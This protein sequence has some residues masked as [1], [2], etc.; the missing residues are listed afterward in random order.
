[1]RIKSYNKKFSLSKANLLRNKKF[2]KLNFNNKRRLYNRIIKKYKSNVKLFK[3]NK[4]VQ[5]NKIKI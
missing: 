1:M 5:N 3:I 2:F 4:T